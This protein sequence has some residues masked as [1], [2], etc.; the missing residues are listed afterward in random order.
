MFF[1]DTDLR[2]ASEIPQLNN[3][4]L[5]YI[6]A[7]SSLLKNISISEANLKQLSLLLK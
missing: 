7:T 3:R 4:Y 5:Q 6:N 2:L 1:F